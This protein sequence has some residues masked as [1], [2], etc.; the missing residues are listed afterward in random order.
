MNVEKLS[1]GKY[2]FRE[3]YKCPLTNKW[4]SVTV[5]YEKHNRHIEK[6]AQKELNKKIEDILSKYA[7]KNT[8][9]TMN[10]LVELYLSD[11]KA[12]SYTHLRAHET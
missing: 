11:A 1:N 12:V 5:T 6:L 2:K 4:K 3:K 7:Q 10:D 9:I 8:D